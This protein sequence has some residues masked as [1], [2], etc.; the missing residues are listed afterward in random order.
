MREIVKTISPKWSW[1]YVLFP[2]TEKSIEYF[3]DLAILTEITEDPMKILILDPG[4]LRL[5]TNLVFLIH[6]NKNTYETQ[7]TLV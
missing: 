6:A 2:E 1:D 3:S 5:A 4:N 7:T